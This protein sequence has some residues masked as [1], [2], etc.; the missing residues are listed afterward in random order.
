MTLCHSLSSRITEAWKDRYLHEDFV[1]HDENQESGQVN[2]TNKNTFSGTE[3]M[4]NSSLNPKLQRRQFLST[5]A[6]T[7]VATGTIVDRL[8]ASDSGDSRR[9]PLGLDAH[10]MRGMRWKATQ[11]I[12]FAAEQRLDAVL[13]NNL[14]Y[15]ESL[16]ESHLL[17]LRAL[18]NKH[19]IRIYM[20][21]GG[22]CENAANFN[23]F[24]FFPTSRPVFPFAA[25]G[26]QPAGSGLHGACFAGGLGTSCVLARGLQF[27][28][29]PTTSS[30]SASRRFRFR[31]HRRGAALQLYAG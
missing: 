28:E 31:H 20:G 11:L 24:F 4:T 12:E 2:G 18:A 16:E 26:L 8:F 27:N 3:F 7:L 19:D 10:S 23:L 6:V 1:Q 29:V 21:A 15:F 13:M 30:Y 17:K 14:N 25:F 9:I 22:V 5:A